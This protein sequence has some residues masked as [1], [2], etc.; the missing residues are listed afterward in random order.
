MTTFE[1]IISQG[2]F[3]RVRRN[4]GLEHATLNILSQQFPRVSMGGHSDVNGFWLIGDVPTDAVEKAVSEALFRMQNGEADL[5]IHPN[6]GTNYVAAGTLAGV[7]SWLSMLRSE[8]GARGK[9]ERLPIVISMATLALI[10]G[11]PLGLLLQARVT[12]SGHP[13]T[14][15]V[16]KITRQQRGRVPAHR[17]TTE[18]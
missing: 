1:Q 13:G 16:V 8:R 9:M 17:V 3:S 4:H 7:V 18:G 6:C 12:T 2:P 11:Q 14:L 5:A 10:L 15:R